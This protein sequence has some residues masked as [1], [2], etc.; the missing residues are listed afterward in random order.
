MLRNALD[1]SKSKNELG[2]EAKVGMND[3]LRTTLES[4]RAEAARLPVE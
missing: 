1:P 2:F 4:F 3:G